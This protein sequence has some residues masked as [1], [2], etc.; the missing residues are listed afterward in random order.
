MESGGFRR[1]TAPVGR[2]RQ[3]REHLPWRMRSGTRSGKWT[4]NAQTGG[5]CS[6]REASPRSAGR[7]PRAKGSPV[8][9][10]Q[11]RSGSIDGVE[12]RVSKDQ[13]GKSGTTVKPGTEGPTFSAEELNSPDGSFTICLSFLVTSRPFFLIPGGPLAQLV[14]Q[15]T[16]NQRAVGSIPTRPTNFQR[17]RQIPPLVTAGGA[18]KGDTQII[19]NPAPSFAHSWPLRRDRPSVQRLGQQTNDGL[20][21][22]NSVRS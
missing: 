3:Y 19:E 6:L 17:L 7:A 11:V 15:L 2:P 1:P 18:P 13:E 5:S 12:D 4:R 21:W 14:E 16:L 8:A 22:V 10:F 9:I 20:A